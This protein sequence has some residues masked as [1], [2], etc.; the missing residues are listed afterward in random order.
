MKAIDPVCDMEV[1]TETA[2]FISEYQGETY[3]F[4]SP[5][6]KRDFDSNPRQYLSGE[7]DRGSRTIGS[8]QM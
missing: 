7:E 8:G 3:Y 1:D 5:G 2:Q 6:C 4:C